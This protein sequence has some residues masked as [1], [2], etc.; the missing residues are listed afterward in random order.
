MTI[1]VVG[2]STCVPSAFR[3][4]NAPP[5]TAATGGNSNTPAAVP[6]SRISTTVPS[7]TVPLNP[8][9]GSTT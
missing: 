5:A 4:A 1:V 9:A 6:L 7:A 3:T 2:E 8:P